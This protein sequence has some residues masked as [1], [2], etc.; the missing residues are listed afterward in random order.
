MATI[1][2]IQG[3]DV[4]STSRTTINTN[5]SN[6]NSDKIE[7]SVIDT[8]TT[9]AANS[10]TK[11]ATQK[12]VKTYVD[13]GGNVNAS[14]TTKGIVE[15]ATDAEVAAGTA[16]GGTG[17]KLFITPAKLIA[18]QGVLL[19]TYQEMAGATTPI[20][21]FITPNGFVQASDANLSGAQKFVG[22]CSTTTSGILPAVVN[23]VTGTSGSFS[24]DCGAGTDRVLIIQIGITGTVRPTAVSWGST[25]LTFLDG[26]TQSN[27]NQSIWYAA[28]GTSGSTQTNTL[29]ITGGTYSFIR[30]IAI[31]ADK[32]NQ[33]T[34]LG[35]SNQATGSSANPASAITLTKGPSLVLSMFTDDGGQSFSS[36]NDGQTNINNAF[37]V[38]QVA[39]RAGYVLS[40]EIASKTYDAT[41][42]G[43]AS[44]IF[45]ALE[46]N[47]TTSSVRIKTRDVQGGFSGLTPG[48]AYYVSDTEGTISTSAGSTSVFVGKALS[49]TQLLVINTNP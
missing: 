11:I 14:E 35:S 47:G 45:M 18:S 8:D 36:W 34:P 43:S 25:S 13:A 37:Q 17:A 7:T 31:T 2:T 9:L 46:L 40:K 27:H 30:T 38:S 44:W 29:T 16:T 23:S 1:T 3:T 10:D 28:I 41:I 48:A 26:D 15:E 6:L 19:D 20:P 21:V 49:A 22:F 42:A 12:A 33:T 24:V 4:I 5:F 39:V 32:V